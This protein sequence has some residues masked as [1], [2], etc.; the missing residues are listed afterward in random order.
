L[1]HRASPQVSVRIRLEALFIF[2]AFAGIGL[3][4]DAVHGDGQSF[5]RL[6]A[7][8]AERHG[9]RGKALHYFLGWLYFFDRNRLGALL[10][11][12]QAA[13]RR[14][15]AALA[16]DEIGVFLKG[17]KAL[18]PHCLLQ[19][20]DGQRIQQVIL[21]IDALVVSSSNRKFGL[22]LGQRTK[23]M[24]VLHCASRASTSRPMPSSRDTVPA[25]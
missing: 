21:A 9:S 8:R 23:C 7:D 17:L 16:V 6:F 10:E 24:L 5:V 12:H 25:K 13:Q 1:L 4:A 19:F 2:A 11:L 22:R 18:L 14:Q 15:V 20:A 3:P